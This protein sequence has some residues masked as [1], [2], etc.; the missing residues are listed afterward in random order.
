MLSQIRQITQIN[1]IDNLQDLLN[2]REFLINCSCLF[3]DKV[4]LK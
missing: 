1:I 4:F 3:L 2:L